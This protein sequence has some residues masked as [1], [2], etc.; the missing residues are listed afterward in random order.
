MFALENCSYINE[1][2][3]MKIIISLFLFISFSTESY[4]VVG[5]QLGTGGLTPHFSGSKRNYCNQWNNSGII[6]NK[7]YYMTLLMGDV[8]FTYMKGNDSICSEIEGIFLLF[9]LKESQ[10]WDIGIQVGGYAFN[11]KNWED[12]AAK[13]PEGIE[14][15]EPL[16]ARINGRAFVPVLALAYNIHLIRR[17]SW[18]LK[19]NNM[20]TPVITNHS[21]AYEFRF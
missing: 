6:V 20:L 1:N 7:T 10:W 12:H 3:F 14:A 9:N 15:P 2:T 19:L 13:T 18:S 5:F 4:A 21:L 17:D 16:T 8:A 11:E